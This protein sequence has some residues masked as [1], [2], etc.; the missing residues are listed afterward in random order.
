M[1]IAQHISLTH[2]YEGYIRDTQELVQGPVG[3]GT[4]AV[5]ILV[6]SKC[7]SVAVAVEVD[8]PSHFLCS[9]DGGPLRENGRTKLRNWTLQNVFNIPVVTVCVAGKT[10][11]DFQKPAFS[12][13]LLAQLRRTPGL[14]DGT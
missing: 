8:G 9:S 13:W 3:D 1:S 6:Q 12:A 14:L 5:D 2:V 10:L 11:K 4:Q 7:G